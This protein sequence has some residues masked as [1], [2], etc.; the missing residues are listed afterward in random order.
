MI[1]GEVVD[2]NRRMNESFFGLLNEINYEEEES[3]LENGRLEGKSDGNYYSLK[4]VFIESLKPFKVVGALSLA[5]LPNLS[6][7][8]A[9][10]RALS[11]P[12]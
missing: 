7:S 6:N 12:F 9:K 2:K 11:M 3:I 4:I 8:T 10:S 5:F 1:F